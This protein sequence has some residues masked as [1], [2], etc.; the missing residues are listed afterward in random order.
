MV[1]ARLGFPTWFSG[2]VLAVRP[3]EYRQCI[4]CVTHCAGRFPTF[5]SLA[6]NQHHP[7]QT[8]SS[9][10]TPS[11]F[12]SSSSSSSSSLF[13]SPCAL[14]S[15][16]SSSYFARLLFLSLPL[17]FYVLILPSPHNHL[18]ISPTATPLPISPLPSFPFWVI[19][20]Y[21][22]SL[23]PPVTK[24]MYH[25]KIVETFSTQMGEKSTVWE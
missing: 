8:P 22:N 11:S 1:S 3:E 24:K 7:T 25:K 19:L 21:S 16:F 17:L 23:A 13:H 10:T 9:S 18:P 14:S 12:S 6:H 2:I 5:L 15:S 4:V 20:V